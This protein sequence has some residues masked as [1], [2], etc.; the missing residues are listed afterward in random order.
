LSS[1][2]GLIAAMTFHKASL[3]ADWAMFSY[4]RAYPAGAHL[5]VYGFA[6]PTGLAVGL[7]LLARLGRAE[8]ARP[9]LIAVGAKLWHC[10]VL[11]GLIAIL[12]GQSSGFEWLELPRYAAV[13]MF[14]AFLLMA[15]WV[16]VT[17]SRRHQPGLYPSQWFVL[18]ALFWFPWIFSTALLLLQLSPV[19]GV[20]Q[21][22]IGWWFA[23]NLL[24]VALPAAALA[25]TLYLIPKLTGRPL[26]SYYLA[27]FLFWTL[28][29]FGAWTGL[30]MHAPLPAWMTTLSGVATVLMILPALAGL[31]I[32]FGTVKRT[33]TPCGGG[34]LCYAKFGILCWG[35]ATLLA[36]VAACPI[37]A[38]ITDFTW[39][40]SGVT[41]L[42][43]YGFIA[44]TLFAAVYHILPA[45][46]G[47]TLDARAVKLHFW[48]A[49]P[50][51]ILTGVPLVIGGIAQGMK[52]ADSAVPFQQTTQA[53][54]MAFRIST[55]GELMIAL[56][57]LLF[58]ANT[59]SLIIGYY[60][61]VARTALTEATALQPLEARS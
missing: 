50:G 52:L 5:F 26:Q 33:T 44:M 48:L 35:L 1:V 4:G 58:F 40:G 16:F 27:L 53:A 19:R 23:G 2:F 46:A 15:I 39:F 6:I 60:R 41:A 34:P 14:V 3:F 51:A 37:V 17:Y 43:L 54:M 21:A 36:A 30:P 42:R 55:L 8:V 32:L 28:L 29:L 24:N 49:L 18:A 9:F 20:A 56:G 61:A 10:G 47:I 11:V 7:W 31:L 38:R 12:S 25:V 22:A 13:L 57:A 45:V 59:F